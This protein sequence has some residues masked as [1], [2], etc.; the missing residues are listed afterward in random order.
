MKPIIQYLLGAAAIVI[1]AAGLKAGA[2]LLNP[3]LLAFL[4]TMCI[5]PVPEWFIRKGVPKG[6]AIVISLVVILL[7][8]FLISTF[9]AASISSL[10]DSI[11]KYQEKLSVF[12]RSLEAFA[13]SHD[14]DISDLIQKA[15]ISPE[16]I[17]G[18]TRKV[19][20]VLTGILSS[21]FIIAMLV[22]FMVI[23]LIGYMVDVR[24][25]KCRE[26][27]Y[28]KWLTAMGGD[29]RKYVTI[30]ALTGVL[31][32]VMNFFLLLILG[33][34]FPFLWAFFSLLMN[35]IP[36]IGIVLAIIPPAL[37]ALITLGW[38]QTLV[39]VGGIWLINAVVENVVRPIFV[40]ETLHISLVTTFLSLLVWGWLLGLPGAV[41]SVP[42]TIM[43]MKI[44][45]DV[46][47]GEE[48]PAPRAGRAS[49][50]AEAKI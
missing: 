27:A 21:S 23:E 7:G 38:W 49:R 10:V 35:F 15:H 2:A 17:I 13:R 24:R 50:K 40:K 33:V 18:L 41:L 4:F 28:M 44:F 37:V 14:L 39:V 20:S 6:L 3:I 19:V 30:T 25:G 48:E 42:L 47:R 36:N 43:V 16:A 45:K 5:T 12:Y 46:G 9:L 1:I 26:T 34:D 29:V 31:T 22:A 11:P 32:A 8:G